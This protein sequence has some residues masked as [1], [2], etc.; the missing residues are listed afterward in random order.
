MVTAPIRAPR[1]KSSRKE[2][3]PRPGRTAK[4]DQ[5]GKRLDDQRNGQNDS[6]RCQSIHA[7]AFDLGNVHSVHDVVQKGNQLGD[8]G[9]NREP[10][11]QGENFAPV[12]LIGDILFGIFDMWHIF[13]VL[14]VDCL[15]TV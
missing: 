10:E 2:P 7:G 14:S 12:Q 4:P 6:E 11:D 5:I 8:H 1:R 3:D 15:V 9:G 13:S